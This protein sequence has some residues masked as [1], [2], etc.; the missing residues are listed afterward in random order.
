MPLY[1]ILWRQH[2]FKASLW[3]MNIFVSLLVHSSILG[4]LFDADI[5]IILLEKVIIFLFFHFEKLHPK[6]HS[7]L[8]YMNWNENSILGCAQPKL[9]MRVTIPTY[10]GHY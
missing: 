2:S 10:W 7:S 6:N 3:N 4:F 5:L 1:C 8:D 9:G